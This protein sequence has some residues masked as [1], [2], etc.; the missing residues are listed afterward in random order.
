MI[1]KI[2]FVISKNC[3]KGV[4]FFQDMTITKQS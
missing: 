4:Y 3:K 2:D 1:K